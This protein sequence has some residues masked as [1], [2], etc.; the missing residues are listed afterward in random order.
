MK[1]LA[2]LANFCIVAIIAL[3]IILSAAILSLLLKFFIWMVM[4]IG[5]IALGAFVICL[6]VFAFVA[7]LIWIF[8]HQTLL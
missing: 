8:K 6:C 4:I 2:T 1:T 5:G 3:M 7:W